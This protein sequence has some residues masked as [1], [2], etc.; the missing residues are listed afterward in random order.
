MPA[1]STAVHLGDTDLGRQRHVCGLF[2]G[3]KDA[4][5][6]LLP[7][8]ADGL[9][10]GDR[11]I[12]IVE[13]PRAYLRRLARRTD[14]S[15]AIESGQLD[16]R[17][18]DTSYLSSGR[19]SGSRVLTFIR[20]SLRDG[21][22]LGFPATRLIGDME[23][24]QDGVPGVEELVAYE[25]GVD[26]LVARPDAWVV[27]AYDVRR[28]SASR[29]TQILG[30]HH[31]AFVDG[32][33]QGLARPG[34]ASS[35]RERILA[36][37][38]L[39]FAENGVSRTGVDTLIAAAGVAK[40]TFYRHFPSKEVLVVVWLQDVR[41]R[42]FDRVRAEAEALA[43]TPDQQVL[44]FFEAL[45]DWLEADD[46]V[47]CP[48]LNTSLETSNPADPVA[49]VIHDYLAEVERYLQG[50]VAAAGHTDAARLGT[51]LH[52]LVA[53]S[54]MLGVANR[55]TANALAARDAAAHLLAA[56]PR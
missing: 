48:Y 37:A 33:L 42:W 55:T 56:S 39:L 45:A 38:S 29:I 18:W 54:I 31:S 25:S 22:A 28:H 21:R 53:G 51:E 16:V 10:R 12:H 19:F 46:Y 43:A 27:C 47:G 3:P 26:A 4:A 6:V 14:V 13:N 8:V 44:R 32:K 2:Q 49:Q 24:A 35:P 40:A 5:D 23:W 9:E 52:T 1:N 17:S 30:A 20:R 36:A 34:E 11:V 7:F 15:G 50:L 41:T